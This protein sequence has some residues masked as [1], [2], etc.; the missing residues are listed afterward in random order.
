MNI[1]LVDDE[2]T[3]NTCRDVANSRAANLSYLGVKTVLE[4]C[5]GPSLSVLESAYSSVNIEVVGNDID[6]RW[7]DYYPNGKWM[8]GDCLTLDYSGYNA[9]VFAPPLSKGCTGKR[10]DSLSIQNVMPSYDHFVDKWYHSRSGVAVLVLPARSLSTT[11]DKREF[12]HLINR[13]YEYNIDVCPI[14]MK[15]G[16]RSIRK[17]VD[18]YLEKR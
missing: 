15:A 2:T 16:K 6:P 11:P 17:Y 4:L 10:S 7:V 12:H 1:S 5:V 3:A 14:Q 8:L 13:L 18:I 9:V